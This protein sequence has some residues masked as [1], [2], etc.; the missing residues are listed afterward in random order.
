MTTNDLPLQ[1]LNFQDAEQALKIRIKGKA[2]RIALPSLLAAERL[3]NGSNPEPFLALGEQKIKALLIFYFC[4]PSS[5]LSSDWLFFII[6]QH[7]DW[8]AEAWLIYAVENL[9]IKNQSPY[10]AL[11]SEIRSKPK[12]KDVAHIVLPKLLARF[13]V[14][15]AQSHFSDFLEVLLGS[16]QHCSVEQLTEILYQRLSKRS[17]SPLQ[18]A[19]LLMAGLWIKPQVFEKK[20]KPL[21]QNKQIVTEQLLEFIRLMRLSREKIFDWPIINS[22]AAALLFKLFAPHCRPQHTNDALK[23]EGREFLYQLII[24]LRQNISNESQKSLFALAAEPNLGD[25]TYHLNNALEKQ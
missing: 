14:K 6:K 22:H 18:K 15:I 3:F 5:N 12:F 21:L 20:L 9:K 11:L 13:P 17:I 19:Y 16:M 1:G 7:S 8:V 25:W 10:T 2:L 4:Q 24:Q 23:D